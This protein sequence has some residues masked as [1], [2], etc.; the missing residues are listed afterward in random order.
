MEKLAY[1]FEEDVP[2][3][4]EK[5]NFAKQEQH[6]SMAVNSIGSRKVKSTFSVK[7]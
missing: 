2:T 3:K 6:K 1:N 5:F 7:K 4:H